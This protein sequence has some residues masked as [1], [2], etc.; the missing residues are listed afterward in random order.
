MAHLHYRIEFVGL[1]RFH[2]VRVP[3]AFYKGVT[4]WIFVFVY[5][6]SIL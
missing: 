6:I 3:G 2:V 1:D 4:M 5:H